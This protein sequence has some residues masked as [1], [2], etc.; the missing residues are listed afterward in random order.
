MTLKYIYD[1]QTSL[2]YLGKNRTLTIMFSWRS[3][4]EQRIL[5]LDRHG[6]Y[7]GNNTF[8]MNF[9]TLT[10]N[11]VACVMSRGKPSSIIPSVAMLAAMCDSTIFITILRGTISPVVMFSRSNCVSLL[12]FGSDSSAAA[13]SSFPKLMWAQPVFFATWA[14]SAALLLPGPP[15]THRTGG[16]AFLVD[17]RWFWDS[18]F[19]GATAMTRVDGRGVATNRS[20]WWWLVELEAVTVDWK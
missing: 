16:H 8:L 10:S 18:A 15:I 17:G 19:V 14:H 11:S 20:D 7:T 3:K 6:W 1:F 5:I 12:V 9:L 4:L 2:M 13:R